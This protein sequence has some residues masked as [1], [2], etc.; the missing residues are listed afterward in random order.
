MRE[1]IARLSLRERTL[2]GLTLMAGVVVVLYLLVLLPQWQRLSAIREDTADL[3]Y[4][5]VQLESNLTI[6]DKV[7]QLYQQ[8]QV[9]PLDPTKTDYIITSDFLREIGAIQG[10]FPSVVVGNIRPLDREV[11]DASSDA[12]A[13]KVKATTGG[14]GEIRAYPVRLTLSGKVPEIIDLVAT[15]THRRMLV[16]LDS[17][18]LDGIQ[19][20][21]Q[22]ECKLEIRRIGLTQITNSDE[23]QVVPN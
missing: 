1:M 5:L 19:G 11:I 12:F 8:A 7:S 21:N 13:K 14:Q 22:V 4:D 9:T 2:A 10:N 20:I 17:F 15:L 18:V 23:E 3:E 16:R 6:R